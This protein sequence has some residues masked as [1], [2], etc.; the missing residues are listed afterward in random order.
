MD[1]GTASKRTR[2]ARRRNT[3]PAAGWEHFDHQ[4]DIG[5]RGFGRS[6]AEAFRNAAVALVAVIANPAKVR[7]VR[8]VSISCRA[9]D[10]EMLLVEWLNKVIYE[11]A[12]RSM[13][14]RSFDVRIAGQRLRAE[15]RGE[16]TDPARH[17]PA[18]EVKGASY[19]EL[20]VERRSDRTWVAQCVVD[21]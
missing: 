18:V 1:A 6:P 20:K 11:M 13:L 3:P 21:V 8:S 12:R 15:A 19:A 9:P 16:R 7:P 5:V 10:P 2:G 14:F 17:Q 4:A